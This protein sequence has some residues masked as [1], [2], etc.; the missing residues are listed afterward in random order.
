MRK[1]DEEEKNS[2]DI[3][4]KK[5]RRQKAGMFRNFFF[6]V[7]K[8]S[9]SNIF[10]VFKFHRVIF[11]VV[12]SSRDPMD[13]LGES[14]NFQFHPHNGPSRGISPPS[15]RGFDEIT[16]VGHTQIPFDETEK[17]E[18]RGG[19]PAGTLLIGKMDV[20]G[21]IAIGDVPM[22]IFNA[23]FS[24]IFNS[25]VVFMSSLNFSKFLDRF[26]TL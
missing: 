10:N 13:Y 11:F 14:S 18:M 17:R 20:R 12:I 26:R 6:F 25:V 5:K 9:F 22:G 15:L 16:V 19:T 4:K 23:N 8:H 3:L 1:N 7:Q 21:R 24:V 2:T